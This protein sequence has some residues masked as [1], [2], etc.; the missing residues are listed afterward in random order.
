[1]IGN[2]TALKIQ[3]KNPQRVNI[4]LDG[5][6]AFGLSKIIAARLRVGQELDDDKI[7]D[8]IEKDQHEV[9]FQHAIKYIGIRERSE[10][11]LRKYMEKQK[12]S[13]HIIDTILDKL[14]Q[15]DLINDQRFAQMWVENRNEFRPRSQRALTFELQQHGISVAIIELALA[16][17]DE[18]KNAY[19]VAKKQSQKYTGLE[20][21]EFRTKI[22]TY[23]A[24]NGFNYDI[25]PPIVNRVWKEN[26]SMNTKY[27]P[28]EVHP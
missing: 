14:I 3:K 6:Y 28:N 19:R 12:Y 2:I 18:E 16:E 1:M 9:A 7:A 23:L 22:F 8:L 24:R 10:F 25:I 4:Y 26:S 21:H 15:A 13:T 11:E 27:A 20:W 17:V 5:E